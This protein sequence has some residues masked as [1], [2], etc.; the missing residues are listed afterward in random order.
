MSPNNTTPAGI[1]SAARW[2]AATLIL[3]ASASNANANANATIYKCPVDGKT[4]YQQQPCDNDN[5]SQG[6]LELEPPSSISKLKIHGNHRPTA[7]APSSRPTFGRNHIRISN[8][9]CQRQ[10]AKTVY[11]ALVSNYSSHL[12]YTVKL[13]STFFFKTDSSAGYQQWDKQ[14]QRLTLAAGSSR[15]I[16]LHSRLH[17]DNVQTRCERDMTFVVAKK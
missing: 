12:A 5:L 14:L 1:A 7:Q 10:G 9:N 2:A 17:G 15:Q 11:S 16:K 8:T 3:F 13:S 6:Q 4:H